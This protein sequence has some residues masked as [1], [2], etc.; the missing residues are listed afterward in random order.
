MADC[1]DCNYRHPLKRNCLLGRDPSKCENPQARRGD[2]KL[3]GRI[4]ELSPEELEEQRRKEEEK[5]R[6]AARSKS[7]L[8]IARDSD[9]T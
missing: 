2:E 5:R 7:R 4:L 6:T 9:W 8:G 3:Y 1:R